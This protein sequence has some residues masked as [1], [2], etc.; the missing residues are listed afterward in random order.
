MSEPT[1][2]FDYEE[3]VLITVFCGGGQ[4]YICGQIVR[5]Y[6]EQVEFWIPSPVG[7]ILVGAFYSLDGWAVAPSSKVASQK[8]REVWQALNSLVNSDT[9]GAEGNVVQMPTRSFE[10][11]DEPPEAS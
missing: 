4:V 10:S 11:T 5:E 1:S 9:V 3:P 8:L 2:E 7:E 6:S